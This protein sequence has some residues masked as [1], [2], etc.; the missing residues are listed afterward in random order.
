MRLRNILINRYWVFFVNEYKAADFF[1]FKYNGEIRWYKHPNEFYWSLEDNMLKIYDVNKNLKAELSFTYDSDEKCIIEGVYLDDPENVKFRFESPSKDYKP[2]NFSPTR[3][4]YPN[5]EIGD[6]TYG[7]P[8]IID[9]PH[10]EIVIGKFCSIAVGVSIVAANH[11]INYVSTYPF[12]TI[13]NPQWRSLDGISDHTSK[14]KTIIGNDVWIGKSA[15]IMNGVNIGDGV[16][17]GAGSIVTKDV[18]PYAVVAGNPAKILKF[19]FEQ[20]IIDKLLKISWWNWEDEKIDDFLH[21]IM[22]EDVNTFIQK[23]EN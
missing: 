11:N 13:W 3:D 18:P 4:T 17:I 6:H 14:G 5:M 12:K 19:R 21:L 9:G 16:V 2:K 20:H 15:F 22:S 8:D 7:I 23:V 1:K 10:G